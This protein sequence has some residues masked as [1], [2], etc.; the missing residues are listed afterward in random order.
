MINWE[1]IWDN[2]EEW[3]IF[4]A[5]EG[6]KPTVNEQRQYIELLVEKQLR[7]NNERST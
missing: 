6:K 2:F 4:D 7:R 5:H 1:K 3:L